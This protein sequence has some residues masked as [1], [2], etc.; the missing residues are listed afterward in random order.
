MTLGFE[1]H[2]NFI[3]PFHEE[4]N[5]KNHEPILIIGIYIPV[6][7]SLVHMVNDFCIRY[8]EISKRERNQKKWGR[9]ESAHLERGRGWWRQ[10]FSWSPGGSASLKSP[11]STMQQG[12]FHL[13]LN[14]C[15]W[16]LSLRP[17]SELDSNRQEWF[18]NQGKGWVKNLA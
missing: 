12:K 10:F 6:V 17:V 3:N 15:S 16:R 1:T 7:G 14:V 4:W 2:V 8:L 9:T 11:N 13:Q 18:K 5:F